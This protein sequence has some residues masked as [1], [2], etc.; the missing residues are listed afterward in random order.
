MKKLILTLLL[1]AAYVG[2]SMAFTEQFQIFDNGLK[3]KSCRTANLNITNEREPM[4]C[5][6]V[7]TPYR[8]GKKEGTLL[9]EFLMNPDNPTSVNIKNEV[10]AVLKEL[11]STPDTEISLSLELT[12]GER[13]YF[14][15]STIHD[16]SSEEWRQ[17]LHVSYDRDNGDY[18]TYI[19]FPIEQLWS[20]TQKLGRSSK[21]RHKYILKRLQNANINFITITATN[22]NQSIQLTIPFQRP[23][24][25]TFNNMVLRIKK[26][27]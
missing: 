11:K 8:G 12:G 17:L 16:W 23:T 1:I 15:P 26:G 19:M 13:L 24:K 27:K 4:F 25:D 22:A 6:Y 18:R 7:F 5:S 9:F 21:S 20:S 3:T 2:V 10:L 14:D